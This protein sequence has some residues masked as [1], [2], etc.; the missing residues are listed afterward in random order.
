MLGFDLIS[1]GWLRRMRHGLWLLALLLFGL[2]MNAQAKLPH[3]HDQRH[4]IDQLEEVWRTAVLHADVNA[5][6]NLLSDDY[7]AITA[8]GTLLTKDQTLDKLRSGKVHVSA[9]ELSDHR[10]RFYAQTAVV[11][12]EA[13]MEGSNSEGE[14]SGHFRYTHVYVK[15]A[16]GV[17]KIVSFEASHIHEAL[18]LH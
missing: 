5:M 1:S 9:L 17:W 6:S 12:S 4:Q 7:I 10:V 3:R 2:Q 15:N 14:V 13:S 18:Q 16:G 11:T 8:R